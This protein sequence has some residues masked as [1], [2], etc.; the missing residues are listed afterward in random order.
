[1]AKRG[2]RRERLDEDG[3]TPMARAFC[4]ELVS[5][6]DLNATQ[7]A[8]RA[9]YSKRSAAS[10]ASELLEKPAIKAFLE[11]RLR[12]RQERLENK[13]ELR[14]DRLD[15]ELARICYFDP[16]KLVNAS[17][18]ALGLHELDEDTRRALG[19]VK[20]RIAKAVR[21][22]KAA[23]AAAQIGFNPG[24]VSDDGDEVPLV[25]QLTIGALEL[26][27]A[28]KVEALHLANRVLGRLKDKVE[29]TT[30]LTHEQ[31]LV[32]AHKLR[33]KKLAARAKAAGGT[34]AAPA[35]GGR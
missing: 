33:E 27:P 14:A 4:L 10:I 31:L 22:P 34:P 2:Q 6:K 25:E 28:P 9:G 3:L 29:V 20:F 32:L 35:R 18:Q 7:A 15:Q 12:A 1:M 21:G 13:L 19:K 16:G 5:S 17:G 24:G 30:K 26:S 11:P 23:G 8:I